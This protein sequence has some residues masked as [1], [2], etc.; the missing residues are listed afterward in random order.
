[1][2]RLG[3]A[4][5]E[6]PKGV[7]VK[8]DNKQVNVKGPKGTLN[9]P[10][11]EGVILAV[12]EGRVL[13]SIDNKLLKGPMHGLYRSLIN[14]AILGVSSEFSKELTLIG[15]GFRAQIKGQVL[16][17]Q[18]GFSHSN[19]IEIPRDLDVKVEKNTSIIISGIDKQ[20]VGQFAATVRALRPPEPYKGK[21]VRYKDEYV[22]KKAG[23][24]A[25]GK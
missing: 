24:A 5:I 10:V 25:K 2:S 23:K 6:L 19:V 22:R 13:V 8:L 17:L 18:L 9:I 20:K 11:P 3:N 1:M 15:V 14:N 7:E 16:D 12:E 21:G 4:P